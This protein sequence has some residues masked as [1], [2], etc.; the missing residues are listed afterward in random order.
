MESGYNDGPMRIC[1]FIPGPLSRGPLGPE[2]LDRR[3]AFLVE[4]AAAS[5]ETDVRD[6]DSGPPSIESAA[7]E[8]LAVPAILDAVPRLAEEGFDAVVI[9]CFGDPGLSAARE[10]VDIPVVG[11]AQASAHLAAQLGN[12]FGILTVVDEVVPQLRR[13]MRYYGL[14][15]LLADCR[16]VDVPVLELRDRRHEVL[17]TL[18]RQGTASLEAGAD[19]LVL[20][21]MTMGF[22]DVAADLGERLGAPVV[23]PVL[24]ALK[25]AEATVACGLAPSRRAYPTPRKAPAGRG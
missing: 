14:E 3:R 15:G 9:G 1:Y 12:R 13:L 4:H 25:A 8:S 11:P 20:G 22:L 5:T 7:E 10:L 19:A 2:E 18:E 16:A 21:C 24:A 23:N 17:G 6:A